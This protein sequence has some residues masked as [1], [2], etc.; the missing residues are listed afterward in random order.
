MSEWQLP[1]GS[2]REVSMHHRLARSGIYVALP[3]PFRCSDARGIAGIS[4]Y[5]QLRVHIGTLYTLA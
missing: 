4:M 2:A 1:G 3:F 5:S